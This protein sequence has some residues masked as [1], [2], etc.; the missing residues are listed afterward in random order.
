MV[1]KPESVMSNGN[2]KK[3]NDAA[4]GRNGPRYRT[5]LTEKFEK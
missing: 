2:V 4:V 1:T 5:R 3:P